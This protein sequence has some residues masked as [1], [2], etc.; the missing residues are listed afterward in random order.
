MEHD[1]IL[2]TQDQIHFWCKPNDAS[3]DTLGLM[4][5]YYIASLQNVILLSEAKKQAECDC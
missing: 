5:F 4:L 2:N 1:G 3:Q